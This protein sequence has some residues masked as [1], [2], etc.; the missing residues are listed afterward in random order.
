MHMR[1]RLLKAHLFEQR[2]SPGSARLVRAGPRVSLCHPEAS[3]TQQYQGA[4]RKK[5]LKLFRFVP[6]R[7]QSNIEFFL[8]LQK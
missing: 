4:I 6:E 7:E 1:L 5:T 2:A 3:R 8:R